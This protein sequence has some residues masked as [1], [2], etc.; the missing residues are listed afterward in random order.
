M[1]ALNSTPLEV[2]AHLRTAFS[3]ILNSPEVNTR[4]L[5]LGVEAVSS[6]PEQLASYGRAERARWGA[7]IQ[8]N[9]ITAD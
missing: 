5:V 8:K 7:V 3:A 4:I 9:G 1:F 2:L 6:T